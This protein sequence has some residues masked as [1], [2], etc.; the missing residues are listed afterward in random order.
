M[1]REDVERTIQKFALQNAVFYKGIANPKAVV[2]KVMGE[3]PEL[4]TDSKEIIPLIERIVHDVNTL[5]FEEQK[6]L[7]KEIDASLLHKEKKERR[8]E[9][10]ELN[11]V[12]GPVVMRIAPGP[13]GPLHLGHS[14]V[15]ILNDEYVRRYGGVL[16]NR[17]EDTNPEKVDPEAYDM[18]KE[19]LEWLGVEVHKT[20]I[21]SD[22]FELYY[23]VV[24]RLTEMGHAYVCLCDNKKWREQKALAVSCPCRDLPVSMQMERLDKLLSSHYAEGEAAAVIKTAIDHPNPALRDFVALRQVNYPHPRTGDRYNVYPMMNLSVAVDDHELG[25]THVLRGKDHLNNTYR[26]EYIYNYLGWEKPVFVH[27]GLVSIPGSILK[28]SVIGR[29]I[30]E[31][32]FEGWDDVR[33]G[34]LRAL[35]RRG[36][37]AEAI[38]RF[39]KEIGIKQ[40]DLQLSWDNLF[41][42]NRELIDANAR[43]LFFVSDPVEVKVLFDGEIKSHCPLHPDRVDMGYRVYEFKGNFIIYLTPEDSDELRS[44]KMVRLKGLCNIKGWNPC[45]YAGD[46]LDVTREGVKVVHWV[47]ES[48]RPTEVLMP[49]GSRVRG[50]LEPVDVIEGEIVQFERFGFVRI[51]SLGDVAKAIY[52]HR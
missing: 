14:R 30:K 38:R 24:R 47:P 31:G 44:G 42:L 7:L 22:R 19:D 26:Q 12:N 18:I 46:E 36:I 40:V 39:W 51:E 6:V 10:P 34:T 3:C 28:T 48:S 16:I 43:R 4:R 23:D 5:S 50:L 1:L 17:F 2:G 41:A 37:K 13:S 33:V 9:L 8:T 35:R 52:T 49:D 32:K 29:G 20:V 45:C 21:Q 27:Y 11:G 15:A 25:M